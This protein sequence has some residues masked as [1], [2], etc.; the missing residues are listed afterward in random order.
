MSTTTKSNNKNLFQMTTFFNTPISTEQ[1]EQSVG[2][3][4]AMRHTVQRRNE[5]QGGDYNVR[6]WHLNGYG[7]QHGWNKLSA[8]QE[9][10]LLDFLSEDDIQGWKDAHAV[11]DHVRKHADNLHTMGRGLLAA[12]DGLSEARKSRLHIHALKVHMELAQD[13]ARAC[14]DLS[15]ENEDRHEFP[16]RQRVTELTAGCKANTESIKW[17]TGKKLEHIAS[18]ADQIIAA[19]RALPFP[20]NEKA[21]LLEMANEHVTGAPYVYGD[22]MA[23]ALHKLMKVM[24]PKH[25]VEADLGAP[26][27]RPEK[28]LAAFEALR[29]CAALTEQ[30]KAKVDEFHANLLQWFAK[31]ALVAQG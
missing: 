9:T 8:D 23:A 31:R 3:M 17:E 13:F 4:D 1:F 7:K 29:A 6:L 10:D 30:S 21:A 18:A 12:V 19:I 15:Q 5:S 16:T 14:Y 2:T 22:D 11:V 28:E 26:W 20:Q 25:A 27:E 24:Q